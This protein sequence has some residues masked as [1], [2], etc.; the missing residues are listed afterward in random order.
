MAATE[1]AHNG[2]RRYMMAML[3]LAVLYHVR[4]PD[5]C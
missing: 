2:N 5:D 3:R 1:V 4:E